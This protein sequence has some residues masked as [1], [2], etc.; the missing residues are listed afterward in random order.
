MEVSVHIAGE[1]ANMTRHIYFIGYLEQTMLNPSNS[2][3]PSGFPTKVIGVLLY[4]RW[5]R[6]IF[7]SMRSLCGQ[8]QWLLLRFQFM[9]GWAL[10]LIARCVHGI[11]SSIDLITYQENLHAYYVDHNFLSAVKRLWKRRATLLSVFSSVGCVCHFAFSEPGSKFKIK[12]DFTCL[13][14]YFSL[15]HSQRCSISCI[16]H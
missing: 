12:K 8:Q 6:S 1:V 11:R 10:I 3:Y 7:S 9:L 5:Y 4:W 13:G 16:R 15:F 2:C 14:Q